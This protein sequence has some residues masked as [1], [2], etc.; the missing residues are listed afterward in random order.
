MEPPSSQFLCKS[1]IGIGAQSHRDGQSRSL[2]ER[3]GVI[4]KPAMQLGRAFEAKRRCQP[5]LR[6]AGPRRLGDNDDATGNAAHRYLH[7]DQIIL[8]PAR[9][10]PRTVPLILETPTRGR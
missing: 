4:H 9:T 2:H 8:V 3:K 10:V 1:A 5:S 6:E 7:T